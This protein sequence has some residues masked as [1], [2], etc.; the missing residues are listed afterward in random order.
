[1]A[2]LKDFA[3][4]LNLHEQGNTS[5][6][7]VLLGRTLGQFRVHVKGARRWPKKGFEGGFDL[8]VRGEILVYPR[9]G[10]TLWVFK[11]WDE[12]ARPELGVSLSH[13]R[14]ASFFCELTEALTRHTAGSARDDPQS[15]D[16][17]RASLYD[18]LAASA[19]ALAAGAHFGPL[20]FTFTL[21]A[22]MLEGL[23]PEL[24]TCTS[25]GRNLEKDKALKKVWLTRQGLRCNDCLTKQ[26]VPPKPGLI[27]QRTEKTDRGVML[28]PE[29]YRV[30]LHLFHSTR[31]IKVSPAAAQQLAH[32]LV[33]L[34]HGALEYDP[35][36]LQSAARMVYAMGASAQKNKELRPER[37]LNR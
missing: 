25:C 4:V 17:A 18:L 20:I 16:T 2:I 14:A 11:E 1:M 19:D 27:D 15:A 21:R 5:L 3:Q 7:A 36:T 34:V 29:G 32:A 13:L 31:P 33:I 24:E 23:L 35:R 22:L 26:A 28:L 12:R 30:M 9:H 6:V 8:L 10:E 37:R